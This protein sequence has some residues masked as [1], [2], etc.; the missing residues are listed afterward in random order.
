MYESS[1][2]PDTGLSVSFA[3]DDWI[4]PVLSLDDVCADAYFRCP[5]GE[6][7]RNFGEERIIITVL[8]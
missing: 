3:T 7:L 1:G 4:I 5:S 8:M 6:D 2:N